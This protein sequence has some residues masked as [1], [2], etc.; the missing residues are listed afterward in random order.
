MKKILLAG[1]LLSA[2][3]LC[4]LETNAAPQ[5]AQMVRLAL[6]RPVSDAF[7]S[8]EARFA[9]DGFILTNVQWARTQNRYTATFSIAD[10]NSDN[11][12]EGTATWLA[13]GQ[14]VN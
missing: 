11:V 5:P 1:L 13:G 7:K 10:M 8:V 6:P 4:I 3:A 9:A 2:S 14:R 12:L